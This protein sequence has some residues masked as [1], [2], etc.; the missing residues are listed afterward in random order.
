MTQ[1]THTKFSA[2]I[3]DN[4]ERILINSASAETPLSEF[5]RPRFLQTLNLSLSFNTDEMILSMVKELKEKVE[6][7]T[8]NDWDVLKMGI[9][10][11]T[12]YDYTTNVDVVP[13]DE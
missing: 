10:L 1:T 2:N 9:P 3:F 7:L 13:N 6:R 12:S 5:T 11:E 4:D 8:D